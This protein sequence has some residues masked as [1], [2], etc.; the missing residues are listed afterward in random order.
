MEEKNLTCSDALRKRI[1]ELCKRRNITTNHLAD[2]AGLRQ[3]TVDA[4]VRGVTKNPGLKSIY[5]IA[6][7][8]GMTLSEFLD[9]PEMNEVEFDDFN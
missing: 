2:M 9:F 6:T 7:G 1:S 8:F 5:Q 4:V 3:S